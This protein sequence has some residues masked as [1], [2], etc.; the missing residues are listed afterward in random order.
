MLYER[1]RSGLLLLTGRALL[2]FSAAGVSAGKYRLNRVKLYLMYVG[3]NN[4][5]YGLCQ[6]LSCR[7]RLKSAIFERTV[8]Q[9]QKNGVVVFFRVTTCV[10]VPRQA[11][12]G[13]MTVPGWSRPGAVPENP[14]PAFVYAK[15]YLGALGQ[16]NAYD[17]FSFTIHIYRRV[18]TW[19]MLHLYRP[20]AYASALDC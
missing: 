3:K 12:T 11:S 9:P 2:G 1:R 15:K 18:Q 7:A 14:G 19:C 6:C 5:A 10:L 8:S 13:L 4:G 20:Y 17:V 16:D